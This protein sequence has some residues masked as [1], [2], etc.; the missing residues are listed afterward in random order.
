MA[1]D[2][3]LSL[4]VLTFTAH[5]KQLCGVCYVLYPSHRNAQNLGVLQHPQ[6]PTCLR[7]CAIT[8][9]TND[10][11]SPIN[12][13]WSIYGCKLDKKYFMEL[14]RNSVIENYDVHANA[15]VTINTKNDRFMHCK[16]VKASCEKVKKYIL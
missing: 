15:V 5:H 6:A 8:L 4:E 9:I 3:F 1:V 16:V 10:N 11:N 12:I 7:P 13:Q 2:K 14:S